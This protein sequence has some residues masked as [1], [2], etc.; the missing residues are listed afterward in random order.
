[1]IGARAR[2]RF[3]LSPARFRAGVI[4]RLQLIGKTI[5]GACSAVVAF[6]FFQMLG[7]A[8]HRHPHHCLA[9]L[10]ADKPAR[11]DLMNRTD[12]NV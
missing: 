9:A 8:T 4:F 3:T 5:G 12:T 11:D 1:L 10:Q 6:E 7:L 2:R